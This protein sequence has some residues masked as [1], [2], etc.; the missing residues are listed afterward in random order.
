MKRIIT[1]LLLAALLLGL[2]ACGRGQT[3]TASD[4]SAFTWQ[5][6][7]LGY[8]VKTALHTDAGVPQ[9]DGAVLD[10]AYDNAPSEG[11]TFLILTLDI[12]KSR[13]G[14]GGFDWQKLTVRDADGNAYSRMADDAFLSSHTYN[15]LPGTALQIGGSRGSIC[16]EIPEKAAKGEMTLVY[17]AGDEGE[18][19]L[20]I[21]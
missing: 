9:Y 19:T 2:C 5:I 16:F 8:E 18:N 7:L 13:A 10:V 6:Q 12:Q 3:R 1:A 21:Q 11:C 17:A 15:R 20:P 4:Q 14:G